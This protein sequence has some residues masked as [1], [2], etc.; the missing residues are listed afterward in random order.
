V[1]TKDE[2]VTQAKIDY[3]SLLKCEVRFGEGYVAS[4]ATPNPFLLSKICL[5]QV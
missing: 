5:N 3:E 1:M 2:K 4:Y